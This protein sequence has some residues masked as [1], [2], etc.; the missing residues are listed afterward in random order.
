[1]IR[2]G[3]LYSLTVSHG[4]CSTQ[5]LQHSTSLQTYADTDHFLRDHSL[6][7]KLT[8]AFAKPMQ[9]STITLQS[10]RQIVTIT[11]TVTADEESTPDCPIAKACDTASVP[12]PP[13]V[14]VIS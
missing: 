3:L 6:Y 5:L 1:M 8:F 4:E 11:V 14:G 12:I 10:P 9:R 2:H 7:V 13:N